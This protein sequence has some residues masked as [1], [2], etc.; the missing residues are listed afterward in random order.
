MNLN[1]ARSAGLLDHGIRH[2]DDLIRHRQRLGLA[3]RDHDE[4]DAEL[5]L[6]LLEL[7]HH[8]LAQIVVER[9]QRLVEQQHR[10]LADQRAGQ[11]DALLLAARQVVRPAPGERVEADLLQHL[12]HAAVARVLRHPLH[13]EAEL[14][15][16][17]HR[18]VREQ[19]EALEHHRGVAM[20][21]RQVGDVVAGDQ[22][23]PGGDLLEPADHP[24]R[25]RLAAARRA[26]QG[27]ELAV[28]DLGVEVDH[29][30]DVAVERLADVD[31][32]DVEIGHRL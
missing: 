5:A 18:A 16:L 21:W 27:D 28:L 17:R 15:V 25:R 6:D 9:A 30:A 11:R 32:N 8:G 14:D 31:Q 3:V 13:L 26:Q 10:R 24:Q 12:H 20:R 22:D 19:R 7:D 1:L 2:D 29:R 23:L 4:G